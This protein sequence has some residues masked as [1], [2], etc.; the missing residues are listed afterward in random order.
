MRAKLH[1]R[2]KILKGFAGFCHNIMEHAEKE[3]KNVL[4]E[5]K[6]IRE[7]L[8]GALS[9]T[10]EMRRIEEKILIDDDFVEKLSVA[11][12]QLIDEYLDGTLP[13]SEH[14]SFDQF[15]LTLPERKQKLRLI[16]DLRKY[17]ANSENQIARQLPK[18]K[19]AF[20][21][22]RRLISLPSFRLAA[23]TL[24][25]LLFG[26]LIWRTVFYQSDVDKGLAELEIGVAGQRLIE[27]RATFNSN[28]APLIVTRGNNDIAINEALR[29]AEFIL[30]QAAKNPSDA[31]A[32]HAYGLVFLANKN[33][34]KALE[35]FN[36]ALIK[37]PD[38]AKLYNDIGAAYLEKA[39]QAETQK[40]DGEKMENLA[41]AEKFVNEALK[42]DGS[43]LEA[44]FNKALVLQKMMVRNEAR[45]AW[46]K[47]LE[48]DSSS[49]WA[50]EARKNLEL[51]KQQSIAPKNKL[52]VL[53][54]FLGAY[55]NKDDARAWE[56][57]SQTKELITDVMIAPQ[58]ARRFLEAS[59]DSRKEEADESRKAFVYLGDLE[60]QNAGDLYFSE[61]ADFYKNSS[62]EQR[63]KL[64]EAHNQLQEGHKLIRKPNLKEALKILQNAKDLFTN[65][66][67]DWEAGIA[68]YQIS[69]CLSQLGNLR[70]SNELL[71]LSAENSEKKDYKW[72][73]TLFYGW[74]GSNYSN[75]G[76]HSRAINYD[77]KSLETAKKT[78][79]S[80]NIQRALNQL[81]NEHQKIGNLHQALDFSYQSLALPSSYYL[82]PRQRFRNLNFATQI[83]VGLKHYD[84]AFSFALENLNL[85]QNEDKD[86]WNTHSVKIQLGTIYGNLQKYIEAYEEFESSL[87]VAL[88]LPDEQ[89]IKQL[90]AKSYLSLGNAQR[91]SGDCG[92]AIDNY[93]QA[94]HL[95]K[96]MELA[97]NNYETEKGKLL[98]YVMQRNDAAVRTE[99][100]ELLKSFDAYRQKLKES[101]RNTFFNAEQLVYDVGID[102]YY[103]NLNDAEQAF[104]YAENSRARSLLNLIQGN[105]ELSQPLSLAEVRGQISP[106]VQMIYYAVVKDKIL[107]WY[108]SNTKFV[109]V[110]KP[111][112]SDELE[113]KI[114]DY[115][116][117]LT[118]KSDNENVTFSAKEFYKLLIEPVESS[119]EKDKSICFVADKSLSRLPFAS[120]VSPKTD[121]YL[122]EDYALLLAPSA[123]VFISQTEIAKQ[124]SQDKNE[125]I[126]S[127]G[128]PAFSR[129]EYPELAENLPNAEQE[130]E[131]IAGLYDARQIFLGRKAVKQ[132]IIDNLN[133]ANVLHFAGHYVPNA[134]SP[135]L[136]KLLLASSDLSVEEI[137]QKKLPRMR[138][139]ILSGCETGIE[140]FY[141]GEG[142][143]GAARAFL[144]SNVP[145]VVASQWSVDSSPTAELMVKFHRY[146]KHKGL[147][148]IAA[149]RQAQIDMM[150]G[151]NQSY[152]QPYYWAGFLPIGGFTEY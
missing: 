89:K 24:L 46:E 60:K 150:T 44:L 84:A 91:Q 149:L 130:A 58:L 77:Q 33:F 27:S 31:E 36:L 16:R 102:Y 87:Q 125:A 140:K 124:K 6:A 128:N 42:F 90:S 106:D 111:I 96:E 85:V 92:A 51:L 113:N 152:R 120:L 134:N 56:I 148:T 132:D 82:P 59:R 10:A 93:N 138:L 137:T 11:E 64:L 18:E 144:A 29:S 139:M 52:Q 37:K 5:Q 9:D 131:E 73:K 107:I 129:E 40:K 66:G 78:S 104:N 141:N 32:L 4:E 126:L 71:Y 47:Y 22:W 151:D 7:Y 19:T 21:D 86:D 133:E 1:K 121:K 112:L 147:P 61:L 53:Q 119:L 72:L 67:D 116:R 55:R 3:G 95:Y 43:L 34:D 83:L 50:N 80:Y 94:S 17:A 135:A 63:Q 98:C 13:D 30:S 62:Q 115:A 23:A 14:K 74:I 136:S 20:F 109:A 25:V 110:Q 70:E 103:S 39:N 127:I 105:S 8:L 38:N 101:E 45:Q 114:L 49:Q 57:V 99:M 145:L 97:V 122:I 12:D 48:K 79:D 15:F 26:S 76:D 100:P 28:Y 75:L 123:T 41:L 117:I 108:V 143:I 118:G 142:M 69:Y 146:R 35:K 65:A 81:T 54:D 2:K 68:D 88:T